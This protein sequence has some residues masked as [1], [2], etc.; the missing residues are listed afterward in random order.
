MRADRGYFCF[1]EVDIQIPF[2]PGMVALIQSKL[3]P[4][5]AVDSMT[6]GYRFPGTQAH[7]AGLVDA[8]AAEVDLLATAIAKLAQLAGKPAV[9]LGAIKQRMYAEAVARLAEETPR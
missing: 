9:T 5:A 1:P 2:T 6:T 8:T 7:E 4:R 3:T